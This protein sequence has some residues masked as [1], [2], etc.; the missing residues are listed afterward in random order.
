MR[1]TGWSI[2]I[3]L[4]LIGVAHAQSTVVGESSPTMLA[5][6]WERT[7][8]TSATSSQLSELADNAFVQIEYALTDRRFAEAERF[9]QIV[10]EASSRLKN[11]RMRQEAVMYKQSILAAQKEY[12]TALAAEKVL[13]SNP[14]DAQAHLTVGKYL[15]F[16]QRS[17]PEGFAHFA[18]CGDEQ[19]KSL[20]ARSLVA[21]EKNAEFRQLADAWWAESPRRS[22]RE[23]FQF[24]M[25]AVYF[26]HRIDRKELG[27]DE[28]RIQLRI[29]SVSNQLNKERFLP[30]LIEIPLMGEITLRLRLIPA[31]KFVMG[32][33]P[34]E[35]GRHPTEPFKPVIIPKPFYMGETEVTQEQW[36]ASLPRSNA[37]LTAGASRLPA[38]KM[39][40]GNT[41]DFVGSL[42]ELPESKR[43][44]FRLPTAAEWEYACRAGTSTAF[45]FGNDPS[46][47]KEYAWYID[48]S[49]THS[50]SVAQKRPNPWGL[51][52]MLGNVQEWTSDT[53]DLPTNVK[54]T[55]QQK[56]EFN[57]AHVARGG[58]YSS[59]PR[60]CRAASRQ[61]FAHHS[62]R[63]FVGLRIVCDILPVDISKP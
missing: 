1:R 17:W 10:T 13:E 19:L 63:D 36:R 60:D 49:D 12:E 5:E 52:D 40:W 16:A 6:Q 51:F 58:D 42:N 35:P 43:Y 34:N 31:G 8:R 59:L 24:Q 38:T 33:P 37:S 25:A 44:R 7:L 50:H 54:L 9:A 45:F 2:V 32:S 21:L 11:T 23:P 4:L 18:R 53:P 62:S 14:D 27:R 46:L 48:G 28:R 57:T 39:Y 29:E 15:C 20:A 55:D 47:L 61:S 41:V 26:Y 3:G 56:E 22:G 30:S